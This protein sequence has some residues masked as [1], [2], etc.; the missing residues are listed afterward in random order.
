MRYVKVSD[1]DGGYP[2]V[3]A[4]LSD[5]VVHVGRVSA[6]AS[7]SPIPWGGTTVTQ[8]FVTVGTDAECN[9]SLPDAPIGAEIE[10]IFNQTTPTLIVHEPSGIGVGLVGSNEISERGGATFKMV[11][12][13]G[14]YKNWVRF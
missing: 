14:P 1:L 12:F 10:I 8:V 13:G 7:W 6:S 5:E 2:S 4:V 11:S 9:V 3:S